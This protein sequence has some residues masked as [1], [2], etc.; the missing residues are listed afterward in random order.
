MENTDKILVGIIVQQFQ[1]IT[2]QEVISQA[3]ELGYT[4][5][6]EDV[7]YVLENMQRRDLLSVIYQDRNNLR[8]KAY[9]MSKPLFKK[10]PEVAHLKDLL[11]TLVNKKEYR[12]FLKMLEGQSSDTKKQ[13]ELGYRDYKTIYLE[14]E[15]TAPI[16]GGS[17]NKPKFIADEIK[18]KVAEIEKKG[19]EKNNENGD[20]VEGIAYLHRDVND[21]PYYPVNMVRQYFLKNLR[22]AGLGDAAIN[23][24]DFNNAII[25][26]NGHKYGL[27]QWAVIIDGRGRGVKTAECLPAGILI[28]TQLSFPFTGTKINSPEMLRKVI[29]YQAENGRGFSCYSKKYGKCKL[30]VFEEKKLPWE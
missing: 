30:V 22:I 24:I 17:L 4:L 18:N 19:A 20:Q 16:V 2:S 5:E 14:F 3:E 26:K 13:R 8:V 21:A 29:E 15:T 23:Q 9:G 1:P 27:E 11:P 7:I 25:E 10:C 28:K 12:D 6:Q